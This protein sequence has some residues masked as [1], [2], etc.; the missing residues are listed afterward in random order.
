MR[1]LMYYAVPIV[2]GYLFLGSITYRFTLRYIYDEEP[3][4]GVASFFW[5]VAWIIYVCIGT[6]KLPGWIIEKLTK[7]RCHKPSIVIG[8]N[9]KITSEDQYQK[10]VMLIGEWE[11][12]V[13]RRLV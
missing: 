13:R 1:Y 11:R 6:L 5:P 9:A 10:M 3:I 4:A 7:L 12:K 8:E 2:L